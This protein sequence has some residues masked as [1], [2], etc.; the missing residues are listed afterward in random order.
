MAAHG[1]L[2]DKRE[3]LNTDPICRTS[4]GHSDIWKLDCQ[5]DSNRL[6][7]STSASPAPQTSC[8]HTRPAH[9][10]NAV[11]GGSHVPPMYQSEHQGRHCAHNSLRSQNE[12]SVYLGVAK[13]SLSRWDQ[14]AEKQKSE[15]KEKKKEKKRKGNFVRGQIRA[16]E[17]AAG[18][19]Q[20]ATSAAQGHQRKGILLV[21]TTTLPQPHP[22]CPPRGPESS[23][24]SHC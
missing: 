21:G 11:L 7:S 14:R 9:A 19:R 2:S 22:S 15:W 3:L 13:N 20:E 17:L 24:F 16:A 6:L 10:A 5:Q 23:I 4:T 1:E 8:H 12:W 18:E